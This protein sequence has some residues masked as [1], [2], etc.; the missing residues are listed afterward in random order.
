MSF[1]LASVGSEVVKERT[2][3]MGGRAARSIECGRATFGRQGGA[4]GAEEAA[5]A[6]RKVHR[7]RPMTRAMHN[8]RLTSAQPLARAPPPSRLTRSAHA[9]SLPSAA[10][11][12]P[13]YPTPARPS[14]RPPRHTHP[15]A[16]MRFPSLALVTLSL[17]SFA[18]AQVFTSTLTC[19]CSLPPLPLSLPLS[20]S[21]GDYGPPPSRTLLTLPP[22]RSAFL[23]RVRG[24]HGQSSPLRPRHARA[25]A[26]SQLER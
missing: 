6:D 7:A 4:E 5:D 25:T 19:E 11:S 16:A 24:R 14:P 8:G 12:C 9:H 26:A 20:P 3:R 2:R 17:A 10:P 13:P 21:S 23:C 1:F 15:L 18:A 22:A